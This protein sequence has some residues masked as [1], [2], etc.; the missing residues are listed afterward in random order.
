MSEVVIGCHFIILG[1]KVD[2]F[3]EV[4]GFA[5]QATFRCSIDD[6]LRKGH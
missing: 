6:H 5:Y 1:D 4:E 2:E 3:I